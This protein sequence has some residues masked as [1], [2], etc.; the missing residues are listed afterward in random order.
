MQYK[1]KSRKHNGIDVRLLFLLCCAGSE[2]RDEMLT[3]S[4]DFYSLSF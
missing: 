1:Q 3:R 4:E 2:V